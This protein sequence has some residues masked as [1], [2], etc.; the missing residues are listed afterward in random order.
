[1][2]REGTFSCRNTPFTIRLKSW[3]LLPVSR[4]CMLETSSSSSS[5]SSYINMP[6]ICDWRFSLRFT[7]CMYKSFGVFTRRRCLVK[8]QRFGTACVS[9]HQGPN[10]KPLVP[11]FYVTRRFN[12]ALTRAR[13]SSISWNR[14]IQSISPSH[15]LKVNFNYI[16]P[17]TPGSSKWPPC[18]MSP[19][20]NSVCT[21]IPYVLRALPI[22]FVFI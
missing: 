18:I 13:R 8:D 16:L 15:F 4:A 21:S 7:C 11:A 10:K 22:S 3:V 19:H 2:A 14:S 20:Q 9:H 5:S 17:S 6:R 1:M 12:S